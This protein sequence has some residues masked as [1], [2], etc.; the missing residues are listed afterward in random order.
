VNRGLVLFGAA[1]CILA[2]TAVL[3]ADRVARVGFVGPESLSRGV[4]AF[5]ERLHELGWIEGKNLIV[6]ARWAEGRVERLPALIDQV[7][8]RNVD[9]LFTYPAVAA[10]KAT[11]TV[12]IV[13]A[14]MGDPVG[15]GLV[16]SLSRP[17]GNLTG[18][19][20]AMAEGFGGK[21][22]ELLH[23]T[24]PRLSTVAVIGNPASPWVKNLRGELESAARTQRLTLRFIQVLDP[25]GL[26]EAFDKAQREAQGALVL[27]DPLISHNWKRILS[28]TAR[29][30]LPTIY[31]NLE[32]AEAGGLMAYGVDTGVS[33]RRAAEY[34]DKI[35]RGAKPGDLPIEQATQYRLVVNLKTAQTLGLV[36][37]E[38]VLLLADKVIR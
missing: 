30:R 19:S 11:S 20:L 6:E 3:A 22:L 29:H 33:F 8:A 37:P 13:A 21:W 12:P 9:V 14:H 2:S 5:W 28:L 26:D 7:I 25:D 38:S 4:T 23:E 36:I 27:G 18:V 15:T 10:K 31:T 32:F 35:L 1:L 24:L 17:G 16:A 34:V